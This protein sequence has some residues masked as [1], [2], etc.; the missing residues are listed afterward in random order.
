MGN[1][2]VLFL[3]RKNQRK[4]ISFLCFECILTFASLV[5]I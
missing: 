5:G 2:K 4:E 3:L 1:Q